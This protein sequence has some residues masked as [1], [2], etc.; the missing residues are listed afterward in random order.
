MLT[1]PDSTKILLRCERISLSSTILPLRAFPFQAIS[2]SVNPK[3]AL[4]ALTKSIVRGEMKD[5][6]VVVVADVF[7]NGLAQICRNYRAVENAQT[8]AN[9]EKALNTDPDFAPFVPASFDKRSDSVQIVLKINALTSKRRNNLK[10]KN[11][12]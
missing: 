9:L 5:E 4:I 7:G 12:K 1:N 2:P 10:S 11:N 3:G 8:L 6:E